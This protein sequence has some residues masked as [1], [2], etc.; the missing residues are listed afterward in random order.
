MIRAFF[1]IIGY[2][3]LIVLGTSVQAKED[4]SAPHTYSVAVEADDVTSRVL[5]NAVAYHLD[6]NVKYVTYPSFD[7]ILTAIETGKADFAGN[8]TYTAHRSKRFEI[9]RPTNI[10]YTYIFSLHGAH[11]SDIDTVGVPKGTIYGRL[12]RKYYP[13]IKQIPYLGHDAAV[14]LLRTHKVE[15]VVDAINQLKPMLLKGFNSSVLN[16]QLPI[17]PVSIIAPTGKHSV[18]LKKIQ[19]Y[20][21]TEDIQRLLSTSI[22]KYQFDIRQQALRLAVKNSHIDLQREYRVKL[23]N[24]SEYTIYHK[25]GD[26]DG[27]S[28][29]VVFQSCKILL[30]KCKLVSTADETWESMYATLLQK[31]IDILSPTIISQKRQS[32]MYFSKSYYSPKVVLIK[33]E[34]YKNNVY[35]NVS[36]LI[37]ERIGVIKDDFYDFLLSRM[38]PNKVL[39]RYPNQEQQIR[40]LLNK[41]VDYIVLSQVNYNHLLQNSAN[42]LPIEEETLIGNLYSSQVAIA[43][44]HNKLGSQLAPLFSR[45]I[46]MLDMNKIINK[47]NVAPDWRGTLIAEKRFNRQSL[48]FLFVLLLLVVSIAYYLHIQSMTDNLTKLKNRRALYRRY[49]RGIPARQTVV[50]LDVNRFKPIND[51]FGHEIGDKVLKALADKINA[52]WMGASYRI[53]GDEFILVG[54]LKGEA[55]INALAAFN[56]FVF[57]DSQRGL[58]FS[59]TVAMGT[60]ED[61]NEHMDIEDVLHHTDIEMYRAKY[62]SREFKSPLVTSE[63]ESRGCPISLTHRESD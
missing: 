21:Y 5:F 27:I 36:E 31:K 38:L 55:L 63:D 2:I 16:D 46:Q 8:V 10:E 51:T 58:S 47:Y 6:F 37:T 14:M 3:G 18:L 33:R 49:K 4:V 29:E 56:R 45:A 25:N 7:A 13:H 41:D 1:T 22:K 34:H 15:G 32:E 50:Y 59:V 42:V 26:V 53:G 28:A 52:S 40:A 54:D 12:I 44:P 43:F 9:S 60:S 57:I 23:E 30:I 39:Y 19:D 61:R 24:L 48:W 11:L 17:K 35:G 62:K 20:A